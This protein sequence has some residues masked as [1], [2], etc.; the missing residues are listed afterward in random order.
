MSFELTPLTTKLAIG[1]ILRLKKYCW[2]NGY[3]KIH[4]SYKKL[5]S[6]VFTTFGISN[7]FANVHIKTVLVKFRYFKLNPFVTNA[8]IPYPLKISENRKIFW[9]FQGEERACIGNKSVKFVVTTG[10]PA[11]IPS[12]KTY[13]I[14]MGFILFTVLLNLIQMQL[15]LLDWNLR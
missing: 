9:C 5:V 10:C 14:K 13:F 12:T 15:S 4:G 6:N 11:C 2:E 7:V 1:N 8:L 3:L